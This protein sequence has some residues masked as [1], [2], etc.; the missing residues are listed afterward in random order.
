MRSRRW[1]EHLKYPNRVSTDSASEHPQA[2]RSRTRFCV[3]DQYCP[4]N[5]RRTSRDSQSTD[6][7]AKVENFRRKEHNLANHEIA[8]FTLKTNEKI[9]SDDNRFQTQ[10]PSFAKS[11]AVLSE[12]SE[13]ARA[14]Q[15]LGVRHNLSSHWRRLVVFVHRHGPVFQKDHWLGDSRQPQGIAGCRCTAHGNRLPSAIGRFDFSF[16]SRLDNTHLKRSAR[17]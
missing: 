12:T 7:V 17:S 4:R 2:V 16:G 8:E 10:S 11:S 1:P 15:S 5:A 3:G 13:S 14:E 9:Q 6:R